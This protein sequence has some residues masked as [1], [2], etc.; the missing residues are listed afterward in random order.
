MHQ[1]KPELRE[2][3]DR[4]WFTT[5]GQETERVYS[6][7]PRVHTRPQTQ[8]QAPNTFQM[9]LDQATGSSS[10]VSPSLCN[11][12][13]SPGPAHGHHAKTSRLNRIW[14]F[15]RLNLF[16]ETV[17]KTNLRIMLFMRVGN[18]VVVRW[19]LSWNVGGITRIRQILW[20]WGLD[21]FGFGIC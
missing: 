16:T 6:Y 4:A 15:Q 1:K 12:R 21:S 10:E 7:N 18:F 17:D 13:G 9:T 20:I 14:A 11:T 19:I 8:H 2:R 5:S 3:T